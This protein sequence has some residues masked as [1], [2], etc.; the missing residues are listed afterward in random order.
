[1]KRCDRTLRLLVVAM[2]GGVGILASG[3]TA[4]KAAGGETSTITSFLQNTTKQEDVK[5]DNT[6]AKQLSMKVVGMS[7]RV[8]NDGKTFISDKGNRTWAG[9]NPDALKG[10]EGY[11]VKV[12]GYLDT[13]NNEINVISVKVRPAY[14]VYRNSHK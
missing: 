6:Q 4:V 14:S 11:Q 2:G 8:S 5:G 13:T 3:V 1:M 10:H 7:G 12:K 9:S